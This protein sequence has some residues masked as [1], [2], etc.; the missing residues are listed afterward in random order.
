MRIVAGTLRG[1]KLHA[2]RGRLI[3]PTAD[4]LRETVFNILGAPATGAAVVLD[5]FAGTGALGIEALS[6]GARLAVFVDNHREA[7]DLIQRNL[8]AC[9]LENRGR[10]LRWDIRQNLNGLRSLAPP[11]DL[12]FMDPPYGHGCI[13]PA[14]ANLR[15]AG[16]AA[17]DARIV[18]EHAPAEAVDDVP[19]GY[20][21][22]ERRR[23]GKTL[24]S[25]LRYVV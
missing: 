16:V 22:D 19:T 15:C 17:A 11:F 24:V 13:R 14:L 18:V 8:N 20:V 25:F 3:R 23:Y 4:R 9:R 6:R 12:I 2:P 10:I 5:L 1:K 7:V 21:L